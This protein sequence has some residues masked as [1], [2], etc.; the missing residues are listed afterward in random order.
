M[1]PVGGRGR[2]DPRTECY[3]PEERSTWSSQALADAPSCLLGQ[4]LPSLRGPVVDLGRADLW[5]SARR[6]PCTA[7]QRGAGVAFSG[8]RSG[9]GTAGRCLIAVP[10]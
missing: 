3:Q 2:R 4:D 6:P 1:L 8:R 9:A 10:A 5:R 7:R